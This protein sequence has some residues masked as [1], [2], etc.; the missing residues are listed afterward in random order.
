M[1]LN[2]SKEENMSF[3]MIKIRALFRS[4][5]DDLFEAHKDWLPE[6]N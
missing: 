4:M 1:W 6:Y 3:S 2:K 5:C